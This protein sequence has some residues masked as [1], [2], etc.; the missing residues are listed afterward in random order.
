MQTRVFGS[1]VYVEMEISVDG[2][3]PLQQ[4]HEIAEQVHDDI[5][6]EFPKVKH[7]MI[8]E[9]PANCPAAP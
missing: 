7:I 8:H 5:E 4:A 1:R 6:N 9:N 3:L 2:T